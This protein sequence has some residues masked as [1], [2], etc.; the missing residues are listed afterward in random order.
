M[1]RKLTISFAGRDTPGVRMRAFVTALR[2]TTA[3]LRDIDKNLSGT[4]EESV[5]LE[6]IGAQ[7][8]SPLSLIIE[9]VPRL[10][11]IQVNPVI[12]SFMD[13]YRRAERGER[14]KYC[15]PKALGRLKELAE[16]GNNGQ[17]SMLSFTVGSETIVPS[18]EL[19]GK[20]DRLLRPSEETHFE[21]MT[22]VGTLESLDVHNV[23]EFKIFSPAYPR[24]IEC[25]FN[26]SLYPNVHAAVRSR[27]SVYG[28]AR[29]EGREPKAVDVEKI[30]L[31]PPNIPQFNDLKAINITDGE[32][33]AD[34]LFKLRHGD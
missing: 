3:I 24:G 28:K 16:I 4:H 10:P 31:L 32:N 20:I 2:L 11:N 15:S 6:I 30:E 7:K 13:D 5:H 12:D 19:A 8:S 26:E 21:F 34:H 29:F 25:F 9:S 18:I 14:P 33:T 23:K 27:V 17:L 22:F 1:Q